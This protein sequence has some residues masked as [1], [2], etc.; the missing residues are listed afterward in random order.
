MFNQSIGFHCAIAWIWVGLNINCIDAYAVLEWVNNTKL[1]IL[2]T[3]HK[4]NK[5]SKHLI[6]NDNFVLIL[7][8]P[9]WTYE[10]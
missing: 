7:S 3:K 4:A 9:P 8:W 10:R 5:Y 2:A 6:H 1:Q